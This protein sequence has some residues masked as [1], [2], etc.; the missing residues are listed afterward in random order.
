MRICWSAGSIAKPSKRCILLLAGMLGGCSTLYEGRYGWAEGWRTAEIASIERASLL[1][2]QNFYRCVRAIPL[3]RRGEESVAVLQYRNMGRT[4]RHAVLLAA[5]HP[6]VVGQRVYVHVERC[7][8]AIA[9][10][11]KE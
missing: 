11:V 9:P 10:R 2:R 5:N 8:G 1:Q 4:R 3:E 7:E 6:W